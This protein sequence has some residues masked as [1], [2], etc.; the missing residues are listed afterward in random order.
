M[1]SKKFSSS[2][3]INNSSLFVDRIQYSKIFAKYELF[4]QILNNTGSIIECGVKE[5]N[6]LMLFAKLSSILEPYNF[7]RKII[8]FDT[9]QGF[10]KINKLDLSNKK[11]FKKL[12]KKGYNNSNSLEI[13]EESIKK[14]DKLN[15]LGHITKIELV[16]GDATKTIPKFL[17]KNKHLLISLLYLDFDL[18]EPTFVALK[19]FLPRMSKGSILVFDELNDPKW[20]GETI[21]LLK[22]LNIKN[23]KLRRFP[24]EPHLTYIYINEKK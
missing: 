10:P 3:E 6:G 19:N 12:Y 11:K 8:G 22:S 2:W 24:F 23:V 1:G 16:K 15:P 5:G 9:F 13:L 20:S 17:K 7:K 21:A 18:F 14:F 4:K